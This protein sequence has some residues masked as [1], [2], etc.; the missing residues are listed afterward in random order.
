MNST[1]ATLKEKNNN[2]VC[3]TKSYVIIIQLQK[4]NK[5]LYLHMKN[6]PILIQLQFLHYVFMTRLFIVKTDVD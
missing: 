2:Y 5:Y 3:H 4:N 6:Y 1:V